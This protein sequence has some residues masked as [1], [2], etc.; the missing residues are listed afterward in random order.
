MILLLLVLGI[1]AIMAGMVV[2]MASFD[3]GSLT[4]FL[5]GAV[6]MAVGALLLGFAGIQAG[7]LQFPPSTPQL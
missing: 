5:L 7:V 3:A 1:L 2:T 6:L 4:G